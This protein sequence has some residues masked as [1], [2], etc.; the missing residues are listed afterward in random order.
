MA[1]DRPGI[2]KAAPALLMPCSS[3]VLSPA[4]ASLLM[5]TPSMTFFVTP[6]MPELMP[7]AIPLAPK[8]TAIFTIEP[9]YPIPISEKMM[10]VAVVV[11]PT[12]R[13]VQN[14]AMEKL[15]ILLATKLP[16]VEKDAP[17]HTTPNAPAVAVDSA[18][19]TAVFTICTGRFHSDH[20]IYAFCSVGR[21]LSRCDA[22]E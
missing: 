14:W 13:L 10:L 20:A 1:F 22:G 6:C 5:S 4:S 9:R 21:L 7:L 2:A 18:A 16:S 12:A 3:P 17:A 8:D 15:A 19:N 11:A